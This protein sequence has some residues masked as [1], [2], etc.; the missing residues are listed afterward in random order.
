MTSPTRRTPAAHLARGIAIAIDSALGLMANACQE[1]ANDHKSGV[2]SA[3]SCSHPSTFDATI[4]F[5]CRGMRLAISLYS[6]S[7]LTP[8]SRA[9]KDQLP[10]L[11]V[12]APCQATHASSRS[13][14]FFKDRI[15][16]CRRARCTSC[17]R[18]IAHASP[19]AAF[20]TSLRLIS[21]RSIAHVTVAVSARASQ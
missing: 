14:T 21:V 11:S 18:W 16:A 7:G 15:S 17:A 1:S 8:I 4:T 12:G 10:F 6:A 5:Y 2:E 9:I 19:K 13:A 20:S 3:G